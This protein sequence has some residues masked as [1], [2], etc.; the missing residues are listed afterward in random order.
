LANPVESLAIPP[1][2]PTSGQAGNRPC[3]NLSE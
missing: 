3:K 2:E 1:F